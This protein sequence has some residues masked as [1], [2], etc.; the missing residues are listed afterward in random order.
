MTAYEVF[1]VPTH[2]QPEPEEGIEPYEDGY[3]F[4]YCLPG[5][6][7]DSEPYGPFASEADAEAAVQE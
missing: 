3:Y 7:P 1:H 4:W 2:Y 6:L 5:C